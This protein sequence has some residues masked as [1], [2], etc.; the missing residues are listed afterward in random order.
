MV[1]RIRQAPHVEGNF[2]TLVSIYLSEENRSELSIFSQSAANYL[3]KLTA[4]P[5][6]PVSEDHYHVSLS[7]HGFLKPHM[8]DAFIDRLRDQTSRTKKSVFYLSPQ[9]E[10]Y[11]NESQN[12]AFVGVPVDLE[13][14]PNCLTLISL[15]DS[16]MTEFGLE[17]YYKPNPRPHVS[18]AFSTQQEG[19]IFTIPPSS[20]FVLQVSNLCDFRVDVDFIT[21]SIGRTFYKFPLS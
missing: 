7:R 17:T 3:E 8:I 14:S 12:T 2:S 1:D 4:R 6:S 16:V 13:I 11:V 5:S 18:L 21:L 19:C 15:V 9:L 10:C 20:P